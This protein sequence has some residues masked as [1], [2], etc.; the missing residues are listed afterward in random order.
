MCESRTR[1]TEQRDTAARRFFVQALRQGPA[2]VE[3]T[4]DKAAAYLRVLDEFAPAAVHVTEQYANNAVE[5]DMAD[6]KHDS[7]RCAA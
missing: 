4:T 6:S 1:L 2:P 3:V 5:A 7:D